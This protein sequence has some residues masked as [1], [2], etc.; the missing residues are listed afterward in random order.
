MVTLLF[1]HPIP[2][3]IQYFNNVLVLCLL[4]VI[5]SFIGDVSDQVVSGE[6]VTLT[7][8]STPSMVDF[9]QKVA[10]VATLTTTTLADKT[11]TFNWDYSINGGY[12]AQAEIAEDSLYYSALSQELAFTIGKMNRTLRLSFA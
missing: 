7:I 1:V 11:F 8:W 4:M 3:E 10:V 6:Q 9:T 12:I 2:R 5:T